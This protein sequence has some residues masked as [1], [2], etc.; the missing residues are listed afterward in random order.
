MA[1]SGFS[2]KPSLT[3][4]RDSHYRY[5]TFVIPKTLGMKYLSAIK[6]EQNNID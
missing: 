5:T 3:W 1:L 2:L 6:K 4:I